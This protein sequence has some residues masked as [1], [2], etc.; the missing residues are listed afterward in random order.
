MKQR[1]KSES[2]KLTQQQRE[3]SKQF[4]IKKVK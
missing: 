1:A 4:R 2:R 3:P